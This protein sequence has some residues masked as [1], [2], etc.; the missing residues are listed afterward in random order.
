MF[1]DLNKLQNTK[2]CGSF[3]IHIAT[4][5]PDNSLH[6]EWNESELM[7]DVSW[8]SLPIEFKNVS[9]F[10]SEVVSTTHRS[11]S[12]KYCV[13]LAHLETTPRSFSRIICCNEYRC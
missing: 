1:D 9:R 6:P 8:E 11:C 3:I 10:F 5:A 13:Q 4:S 12:E 2:I 7:D